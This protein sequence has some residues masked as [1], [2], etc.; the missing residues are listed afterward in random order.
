MEKLPD[1]WSDIDGPMLLGLA[2]R[3]ATGDSVVRVTEVGDSLG[4]DEDTAMRSAEALVDAGYLEGWGMAEIAGVLDVHKPHREGS[5]RGRTVAKHRGRRRAPPRCTGPARQNTP[6]PKTSAPAG[7]VSETTS[8][9][10]GRRWA[11]PSS[12]P[13]SLA[14]YPGSSR[15]GPSSCCGRGARSRPLRTPN[16]SPAASAYA[17]HGRSTVQPPHRTSAS[18]RDTSPSNHPSESDGMVEVDQLPAPPAAPRRAPGRS[19]G[20]RSRR[21]PLQ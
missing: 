1:T 21:A 2:R 9:A 18:A 6:R 13:C 20:W 3:L 4:L 12:R 16:V 14:N 8:R 15:G 10:T 17:L 5:P 11:G 7:S 19:L